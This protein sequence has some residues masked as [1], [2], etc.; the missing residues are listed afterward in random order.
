M[1]FSF[2]VSI[3]PVCMRILLAKVNTCPSMTR[4]RRLVA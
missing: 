3:V 1:M 2:P 4:E